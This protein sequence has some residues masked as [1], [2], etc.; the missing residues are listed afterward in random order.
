[1]PN[2][3]KSKRPPW[4]PE[5]I[6]HQRKNHNAA[7]YKGAAWERLASAHKRANPLCVHCLAKGM[8]TPVWATDHIRPMNQGGAPLAWDNLQSLCRACHDLKSAGES[9]PGKV[10]GVVHP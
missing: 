8:R 10:G 4:M 7:F 2:M 6:Q 9:R 5:R 1:M 3:P